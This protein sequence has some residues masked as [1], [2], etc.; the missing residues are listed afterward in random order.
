MDWLFRRRAGWI[1]YA[2]LRGRHRGERIAGPRPPLRGLG[3]LGIEFDEALN[4]RAA[5][6]ISAKNSR[7][8]V[9]IIRTDE[10]LMIARSV[11]RIL[12]KD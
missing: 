10:E 8:T 1:G 5:E 6:V 4:A 11:C 2:C 9:R 3:F 7:V 12:K